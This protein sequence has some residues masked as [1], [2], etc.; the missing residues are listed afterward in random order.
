MKVGGMK[1]GYKFTRQKRG[2]PEVR[3]VCQAAARVGVSHSN[4]EKEYM[5]KA[6]CSVVCP[7]CRPMYRNLRD[8]LK[9]QSEEF[10]NFLPEWITLVY[11]D[12]IRYH[13]N[14][15]CTHCGG[16]GVPVWNRFL[17]IQCWIENR[18][19]PSGESEFYKRTAI[20]IY[21]GKE[22]EN[23][24]DVIIYSHKKYTQEELRKLIPSEGDL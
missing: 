6:Y 1:K 5:T 20:R 21:Y 12:G 19:A 4:C 11:P 14:K 24:G 7:A 18:W 8:R 22:V 16:K 10:W 15:R 17:C 2:H 23:P 13:E 3:K 9:K